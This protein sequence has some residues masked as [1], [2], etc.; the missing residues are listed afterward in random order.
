MIPLPLLTKKQIAVMGLGKSGMATLAALRTA[1]I[2]FTAWDDGE[3]ARAEALAQ[4]YV[5]QDL[6]Q[7]DWGQI[8]SLVLSPGIPHTFP[9]PHPVAAQA[10]QHGVE[11]VGDVEYLFRA[12]PNVRYVGITGTNGKSTTTALIAHILKA[13]GVKT[14]VGGNLG[15]PV[16]ALAP[17]PNDGAYVIEMSSYQCELTPSAAFDVA[18]WLNIT[19]DH[20]DRHGSMEGYIAAKETMLRDAGKKQT[21]VIGVD[22]AYSAKVAAAFERKGH[23]QVVPISSNAVLEKGVSGFGGWLYEN[24]NKLFSYQAAA[25]LPGAHN[26][27]NIAAAFVACRAMGLPADVI[28]RHIPTYPGLH[29]RQELVRIIQGIRFINDSK[30]T[31]ADAASKALSCYD[32]IYWIL[33]GKPKEGGLA[34]LEALMP[35]VRHAFLIGAASDAFAEWLGKNKTPFSFCATL[36][37]AVEGA[38]QM[39]ATE[40]LADGVV[41]LSPACASFDQFQNYEH[42]GDEFARFVKALP[43]TPLRQN[44]IA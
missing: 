34:G 33:G 25:T 30:A 3:K 37:C 4:G 13:A 27:Q 21:L 9:E 29:H 28:A 32:T 17:L 35:R 18:V 42:R 40:N 11:I 20:I 44:R 12:M 36:D 16:L 8:G 23:W 19:P 38:A 15:M 24:G 5:L 2:G 41:L 26:A 1:G 39:A 43:E 22:D 31:N 7:V 10:K 6:R 14:E